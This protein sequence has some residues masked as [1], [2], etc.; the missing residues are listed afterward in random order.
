ML[1][2]KQFVMRESLLTHMLSAG[3]ES[4]RAIYHGAVASL[5]WLGVRLLLQDWD[6]RGV[7]IDF[8][9]LT[10]AF[11]Q[12]DTVMAAWV[13]MTVASMA[14]IP[15]VQYLKA[16][17]NDWRAFHRV[18]WGYYALQ[19]FLFAYATYK[20]MTAT[21]PP[22]SGLIVVCECARLSMKC[23]AYMREKTVHGLRRH[24]AAITGASIGPLALAPAPAVTGSVS[25]AASSTSGAGSSGGG[26][27]S[28]SGIGSVDL[29][30]SSSA[31]WTPMVGD[32]SSSNN[33]ASASA[34]GS[35]VTSPSAAGG[36]EPPATSHTPAAGG[37]SVG[38]STGGPTASGTGNS[39]TATRSAGRSS[40]GSVA[41]TGTGTGAPRK[42]LQEALASFANYLPP[43]AA[44]AGIETA[45][46][47]AAQP[48]ITIG[49]ANEEIG[50]FVFF[51]FAPTLVYRDE[52]PRNP[53][54]I[55]WLRAG[56]HTANLI[57][58]V[59]Y[60]YVI[61]RSLLMPLL[62]P[63]PPRGLM[64][65]VL[66]VQG[67][68]V[69]SMLAFLLAFFGILHSWLNVW[70][71]LLRFA[72]RQFYTSWWTATT[73]SAYY[74]RWNQVV[75]DFLHAYLY[76]DLQRAGYRRSKAEAGVF[77]ISALIH[78]WILA[79]A[80][81]FWYPVLLLMFGGPGVYFM[82]LTRKFAS[83]FANVFMWMM[84]SVGLAI[85]TV[86]YA[87]ELYARYGWTWADHPGVPSG[88]PPYLFN[89]H[90]HPSEDW[91]VFDWISYIIIPRSWLEFAGYGLGHGGTS[92]S[93]A[94]GSAQAG[95]QGL[96][97]GSVDSGMSSLAGLQ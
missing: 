55:N 13:V 50:R 65:L 70:A 46:L 11:S 15:L 39:T 16:N 59:L 68:M 23:H 53:G 83:R 8:G 42:S 57:G 7:I 66:L 26:R 28:A 34:S 38:S 93:L 31:P 47:V 41:T 19:A 86:T 87:R 18:K 45:S 81:R 36:G 63:V 20:C 3:D 32:A 67:A 79:C 43:E 25:S 58:V 96:G 30:S 40:S 88:Q 35:T 4:Y 77:V 44:Q 85:L 97:A 6:K 56:V 29:S 5:L 52:Y 89:P 74:R 48:A 54:P 17:P 49:D 62:I 2:E 10:W 91:G 9:L 71:E 33:A 75:G 92:T 76:N 73:W 78:E 69:P 27:G 90:M 1:H 82:N 80:F 21:L 37:D 64:D 72:D 95:L 94:V 84:L 60:T 22:A 61:I 12:M 14:V 24:Y 51:Q